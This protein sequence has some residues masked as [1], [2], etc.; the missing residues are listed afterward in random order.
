[1]ILLSDLERE[2]ESMSKRDLR[3]V[4]GLLM[5]IIGKRFPRK[6]REQH[7]EGN[8]KCGCPICLDYT[9]DD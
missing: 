2:F 9:E 4:C 1:M 5:H 8:A 6:K 7:F 3:K